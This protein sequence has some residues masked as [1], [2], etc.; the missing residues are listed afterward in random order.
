MKGFSRKET[1]AYYESIV[2]RAWSQVQSATTPEIKSRYFDQGLE[3]M[4]M[5]EKFEERSTRTVGDGP[6]L[7]PSWWAYYRPWV[8]MVRSS[9]G[10]SSG[11]A[12]G[13][14]RSRAARSAGSG[15]GGRQIT[16]PTLPGAAF[17]ST[18]VG[19]IERSAGNVVGRLESFT[20]GVTQRTHP[21]PT[22]T[23]SRSSS[24]RSGGCACACACACAGCACACAGGGR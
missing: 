22:S 18:V 14:G 21:A 10:G 23:G 13:S 17:A 6:F 24:H 20:G 4:M 12:G 7:M 2:D 3:W 19:G 15:G 5:D 1:V 11:S 16:L 9:R 8:P